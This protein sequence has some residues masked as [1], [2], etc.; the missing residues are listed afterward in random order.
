MD[1]AVAVFPAVHLSMSDAAT[2]YKC[3]RG[4][5]MEPT[6]SFHGAPQKAR[7]IE[8]LHLANAQH[9]I[10]ARSWEEENLG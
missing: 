1:L 6:N 10:G 8:R 2:Q 5:E 4:Q 9:A 3:N 7:E